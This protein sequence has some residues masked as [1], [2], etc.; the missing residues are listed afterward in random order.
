MRDFKVS[1]ASLDQA[2]IRRG[3]RSTFAA[4]LHDFALSSPDGRRCVAVVHVVAFLALGPHLPGIQAATPVGEPQLDRPTLHSLGVYWILREDAG[5]TAS[6][7]L[8]YR[9]DGAMAW[10]SGAPLLRVERGA[11]LMGRHGSRLDVPP[12]GW[13]FAGSA[14]CWSR[15]Q[16]TSS[17]SRCS[18][19]LRRGTRSRV[20][21]AVS[22]LLRAQTRSEPRI[23]A[24][25]RRRHVVPGSG[26]G[27]GT[28]RG[29]VSGPGGRPLGF[30]AGRSVF[31]PR[32]ALCRSLGPPS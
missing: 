6:I 17:G 9:K 3:A 15:R 31:A 25:A 30:D 11:H 4:I 8:E 32:R 1:S 19:R 14:S 20:G 10:R 21:P 28:E 27:S 2:G 26:G 18:T 5:R 7:R 12:D 24:G 29:S 13:L 22:R 23:S 16:P